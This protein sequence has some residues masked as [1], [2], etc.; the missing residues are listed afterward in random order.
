VVVSI[1]RQLHK[2]LFTTFSM[3]ILLPM[4]VVGAGS[5]PASLFF[6][7][8]E[9]QWEEPFAFKASV[10]NAIYYVTPTGMTMDIREYEKPQRTRDP[11][12]RFERMHEQ[13]LTTVRGH[14]LRF[15][16]LNAN[17]SPEII[18]EDKLSSYSNYFLGRDSCKW[19][20][21][22]GHYQTVRMKNV[23][24]GIDVVQQ[25]QPEGVETLY[26]VQAG[27]NAAQI[28]VQVEGLTA[29][30]RVDGAGNL[31][32]STSLGEVKEKA[33]FA[34]QII[35]HR[36]VEV[37]VQYQ[38]LANDKYSLSFEAFDAGHELVID[39]MVY[40]TYFGAAGGGLDINHIAIDAAGNKIVSGETNI[41]HFP[42]APGAYQDSLRG[43]LDIFV[44]KLTADAHSVVFF[45]YLGAARNNETYYALRVLPDRNDA[46]Y[47][48][49]ALNTWNF[50]LTANA[51][52]TTFGGEWEDYI[53]RFSPSG[54]ALEFSSF[55]GG[56]GNEGMSNIEQDSTG[57]IY[58][59]GVT[60]SP[61]FP[62]TPDALFS[63]Y[64]YL[65]DPFIT[66]FDPA[67]STIR[68]STYFP[69]GI[70]SDCN[71]AV[72]VSPM[73]VWIYGACY[74]GGI[75]TT[76]DALQPDFQGEF[77]GYFSLLD[78]GA[79][80]VVYSSYIGGHGAAFVY[81]CHPSE[82]GLLLAGFTSSPDF[83]VTEGA[84]DTVRR[85]TKGF[86]TLLELPHAIFRS[87]LYG[88]AFLMYAIAEPS[89][90]V[91]ALGSTWSPTM[92]VTP[93]AVS[94]T[95]HGTWDY[96]LC[97]L[98]PD[99]SRLQYGTYLGGS[100]EEAS[101][102]IGFF[103]MTTDTAG[104]YWLAGSTPSWDFPTTPDALLPTDPSGWWNSDGFVSHFVFWD[105]TG[106]ANP[107]ILL[108]E[109]YSLT[110]FPN[111]FNS[112]TILS[113]ILPVTTSAGLRLYDVTGRMVLDESLG[114]LPAGAHQVRL[115]MSQFASGSYLARLETGQHSA[116][117]KMVM[118]R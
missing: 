103:A 5:L 91:V 77:N 111:P 13:E 90:S 17:S 7:A 65:D 78:L 70:S 10:G 117:T 22:V 105:T 63:N 73:R 69:G 42:I 34:Y 107:R 4:V 96:F 68:Y 26:R 115:D 84:F 100:D 61:D 87:T 12:D 93:D 75:P 20:S 82:S 43:E 38:V 109:T 28:S 21:F 31:L 80:Q 52:D 44:S 118:I 66:V 81:T 18:G 55:L 1:M 97:R 24:P 62:I 99:L 16:F 51:F 95:L 64:V 19:R 49:G 39:P 29:P 41:P 92:P 37:P 67:S 23:W 3:A 76:P 108:P 30:L 85:G 53:S 40:S 54:S 86:V 27:A 60:T 6:V 45:T 32:L 47:I 72:V 89:G 113:F 94:A 56:S 83:P 116:V 48:A 106:A 57:L 25:V 46:I 110:V 98:S 11:M 102:G 36:Q 79:R 2:H 104:S 14:V 58:L 88:Y 74:Q 33:P 8:N 9:G 35:D 59:T 101:S 71:G 114:T 15:S 50:P 112:A